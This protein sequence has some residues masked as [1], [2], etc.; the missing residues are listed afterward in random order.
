MDDKNLE[1]VFTALCSEIGGKKCP[2]LWPRIRMAIGP[3]RKA[4]K[5]RRLRAV[6]FAAALLAVVFCIPGVS[7]TV[8]DGL[9]RIFLSSY[10]I[11]VPYAGEIS[12][13]LVSA[14]GEEREF[15][16][17]DTVLLVKV[18]SFGENSVKVDVSVFVERD[19]YGKPERRLIAKPAVVGV[20]GRPLEMRIG[21]GEQEFV[22]K[23]TPSERNA[24]DYSTVM[25]PR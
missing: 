8:R 15:K 25:V 18:S 20:V 11:K 16:S 6:G 12:G 2:D 4:N 5:Y 10:F 23:M 14:D 3:V 19:V 21:G 22:L 13:E 1:K 9:A 7:Q 24:K 17:G